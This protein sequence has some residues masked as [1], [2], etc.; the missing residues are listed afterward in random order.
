MGKL[1]RKI[2]NDGHTSLEKWGIFC[3][4]HRFRLPHAGRCRGSSAHFFSRHV[5]NFDP[6]LGGRWS[7]DTNNSSIMCMKVVEASKVGLCLLFFIQITQFRDILLHKS[8]PR[9]PRTW[10]TTSHCKGDGLEN[11]GADGACYSPPV[12]TINSVWWLPRPVFCPPAPSP[13]GRSL[14]A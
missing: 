2:A 5:H 4:V 13:R 9:K 1:W 7:D 10:L 11:A 8:R 3:C 6:F 12:L 14:R